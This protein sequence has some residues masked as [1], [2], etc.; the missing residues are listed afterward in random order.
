MSPPVNYK[1]LTRGCTGHGWIPKCS[2][3]GTK[4]FVGGYHSVRWRVPQ[5]SP[6]GTTVFASG[7]RVRR[8]IPTNVTGG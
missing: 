4:V 1:Q 8:W 7:Y 6:E 5:C 3:V 2:L